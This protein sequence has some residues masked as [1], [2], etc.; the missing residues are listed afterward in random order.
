MFKQ[1]QAAI[2]YGGLVNVY[3]VYEISKN[4]SII[5]YPALENCLF[6]AVSLTKNADID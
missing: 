5:D 3:S 6:W 2:L 4:I 1:D